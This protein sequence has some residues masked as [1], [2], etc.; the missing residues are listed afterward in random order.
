M[1]GRSAEA[2]PNVLAIMT[3]SVSVAMVALAPLPFTLDTWHAKVP[4]LSVSGSKLEPW[5][6]WHMNSS[7]GLLS[8]CDGSG[9]M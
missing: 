7:L 4:T 6:R 3:V 1:D 8:V 2:F 5:A 9:L